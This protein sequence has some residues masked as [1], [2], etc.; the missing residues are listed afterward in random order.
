MAEDF[1]YTF[2]NDLSELDRLGR[3][4]DRF[5]QLLGLNKKCLFEIHLAL[6]EHFT[7][8]VSHGYQDAHEHTIKVSLAH[9]NNRIEIKIED[10]GIPFNPLEISAPDVRCGIEDRKIGGL[11]IHIAKHCVDKVEYQRKNDRNV[12]ILKKYVGDS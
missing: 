7:N 8:V 9:A 4:V 12:L 10:D 3:E 2:K 11:G 1:S 5:G 6:E